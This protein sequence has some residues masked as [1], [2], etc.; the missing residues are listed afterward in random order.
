MDQQKSMANIFGPVIYSYTR[1][2]A[3]EDGVLVDVSETAKDAGFKFPVA[4]TRAAWEDCVAW[5]TDD[6][7][8]HKTY[9]DE[10]GRLWDVVYMLFFAIKCSHCDKPEM[11]FKLHRVPRN[12]RGRLPKEIVLKSHIGPGDTPDPVITIMLPHED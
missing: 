1:S 2:Q 5:S 11:L 8:R 3:I 10:P 12:G 4:M 7:K 6:D 9:Q